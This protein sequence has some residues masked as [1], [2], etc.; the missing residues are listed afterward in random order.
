MKIQIR[1]GMFETN[2]SSNHSLIITNAKCKKDEIKKH[3]NKMEEDYFCQG[4]FND[5]I[6]SK[7]DKIL[8]LGGLFDYE[9]QTF[10]WMKVE[11]SV[12]IKLLQDNNELTLIEKL[13][14]NQKEYKKTK[15]EP[16]CSNYYYHGCLCDCTCSFYKKFKE[17][18]NYGPIR[19]VDL[20][21]DERVRNIDDVDERLAYIENIITE[22]KKDLYNKLHDF[23]YGDGI[24]LAYE[25]I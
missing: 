24:I 19:Q 1:K 16:Y 20:F 2:S 21:L 25:S 17:Y 13:K 14:E 6:S 9:M 23:I 11:Y 3:K 12:F 4:F 5:E 10:E 22:N 7:E 8:M 15:D 18:F